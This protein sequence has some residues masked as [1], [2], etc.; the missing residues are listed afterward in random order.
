MIKYLKIKAQVDRL[1]KENSFSLE[2]EQEKE[3]FSL[4]LE[5]LGYIGSKLGQL[6]I[7][8]SQNSEES[9]KNSEV[10][11]DYQYILSLIVKTLSWKSSSLTLV[12]T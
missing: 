1:G 3:S 12:S 11:I 7:V 2:L 4:Y 10:L 8:F 9:T 5:N 6:G